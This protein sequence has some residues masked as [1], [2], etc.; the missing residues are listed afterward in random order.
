VPP[1]RPDIIIIIIIIIITTIIITQT[2]SSPSP[3][4]DI[5]RLL[6]IVRPGLQGYPALPNAASD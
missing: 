2:F 4:A 1:L 5:E 3:I 6:P